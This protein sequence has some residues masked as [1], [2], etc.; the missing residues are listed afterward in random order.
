MQ[1]VHSSPEHSLCHSASEHGTAEHAPSLTDDDVPEVQ[2]D[3]VDDLNHTIT[4]R[5]GNG[6]ALEVSVNP[7][8]LVSRVKEFIEV[9]SFAVFKLD[10][11]FL[12]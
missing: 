8:T 12:L 11:R 6:D 1:G 2:E 10:K 7:S 3:V 9:R 5:G 4:V